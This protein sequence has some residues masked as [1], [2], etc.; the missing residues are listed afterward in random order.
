[1]PYLLLKD[2]IV[3]ALKLSNLPPT[4]QQQLLA[5]MVEIAEDRIVNRL[6]L[7]LDDKQ[8]E[9]LTRLIDTVGAP[10][11]AAYLQ[12]EVPKFSKIVLEEI[13]KYRNETADI[14]KQ[15]TT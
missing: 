1:M 3:E 11:V 9:H 13:E 12:H 6:L 5:D 8:Q 2:S 15:V 14:I 10:A 7:E 4:T